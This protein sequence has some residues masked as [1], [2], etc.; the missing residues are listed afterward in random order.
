MLILYLTNEKTNY[1]IKEN[2]TFR[3]I[4]YY[5]LLINTQ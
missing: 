3:S 5:I 2:V 1:T 4:F